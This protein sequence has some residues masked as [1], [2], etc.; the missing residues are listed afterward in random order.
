MNALLRLINRPTLRVTNP[1][2][3]PASTA[4]TI[5]VAFLLLACSGYAQ[6]SQATVGEFTNRLQA[7][8]AE[9]INQVLSLARSST[10]DLVVRGDT[11]L[12]NVV[13]KSN[14]LSL[15]FSRE[16]LD[17][18]IGSFEFEA[19][20][21]R[22][23]FAASEA[24]G[25]DFRNIEFSTL[26]GGIPLPDL[27]HEIA[28]P[29]DAKTPI[30]PAATPSANLISGRRIAIS[31]GHG[32]Y[33]TGTAWSLQRS[34]FFGIVEDFVNS[35]ITAYLNTA[36]VA[37]GADSRPTRNLNKSAGNGESGFP[38]WQEAAR[39]YLK[40][41]GV[42]S[43]I[44]N[45]AGY[46]QL[47][48]DIRCRPRYANSVAS[49]ILVSIHNNGGGGTG[50]ETWYDTS[51]GY[52]V[53]SKRLAEFVHARVINAIR[54]SYNSSWTDRGVKGADGNYGE[55]HWATRPS[56]LIEIAFMDKQT[57]DNAALQSETFKSLVATAIKD[58]I[59][60]YFG[61]T[62]NPPSAA[63]ATSNPHRTG[64]TFTLSVPTQV[65]FNYTLEYKNSLSDANW[66]AGQMTSGTGGTIT[67]TDTGA[68]GSRRF[69]HVH[70]Q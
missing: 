60:D 51:N 42:D 57:P 70:V 4:F 31:P 6:I 7:K 11:Q 2:R 24:L 41:I 58:G 14:Q 36:L 5:V 28:P 16:L 13:L 68:T 15:N 20:M 37:A 8:S 50:T 10:N 56:C 30:A 12:L 54:S 32:Y 19:I 39:Y 47:E 63:V 66:T 65:G 40:A 34:Y 52:S 27:L 33:Y 22:I 67:L 62:V 23:H 9:A 55:N 59:D 38:K 25:E 18:R 45:E 29:V 64:T 21:H 26:I 1:Y 44:W 69:Y 46:T 48:Q 53:E 49:D 35:D 17:Y 43:S 61:G 3:H